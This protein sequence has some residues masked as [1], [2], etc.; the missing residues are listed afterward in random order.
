MSTPFRGTDTSTTKL[1]IQWTSASYPTNGNSDIISYNLV[2]DAGTGT[3]NQDVIGV[4]TDYSQNIY[5]I[6]TGIAPG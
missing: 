2:W 1:V 6:T 5:T 4:N 3:T